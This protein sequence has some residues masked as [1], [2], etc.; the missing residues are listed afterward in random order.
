MAELLTGRVAI[1]TGAAQGIGRGI[2]RMFAAEGARV[3]VVDLDKDGAQAVADDI[4]DDVG[5]SSAIAVACDVGDRRQVDEAVRA[6]VDAFGTVDILVNT[7]IAGAPRVPFLETTEELAEA[8]WRTGPLGTMHFT[9]ACHPFMKG[10][11]AKIINFASG[12]GYDGQVG[13][14]AYAPAKEGVRALTKVAAREL[15]PDGIRVNAIFPAAKTRLMQAWMD[16]D[17]ERAAAVEAAVPL[18]RFG[19]PDVDIPLAVVFLASDYS[20]YVTG[21]TLAVDGGSCKF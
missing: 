21:H 20:R 8:M 6:T 4:V 3:A 5:P 19:D 16:E 17:P 12:G 10:R 9:Q 15:G 14:A 1:V 11:D 13:Y 7:A 18:G 2:A